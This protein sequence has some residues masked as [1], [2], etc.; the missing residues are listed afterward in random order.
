M[1]A[2][3]MPCL[4]NPHRA[5]MV[6]VCTYSLSGH[7]SLVALRGLTTCY[8]WGNLNS[9]RPTL[10]GFIAAIVPIYLSH[11]LVCQS[12]IWNLIK[13]KTALG[14][15]ISFNNI[16]WKWSEPKLHVRSGSCGPRNGWWEGRGNFRNFV[17]N[18]N[19]KLLVIHLLVTQLQVA[20]ANRI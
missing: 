13:E 2:I 8:M 20:V 17:T 9:K 7:C 5:I 3:P 18:L 1:S 15:S 10:H 19:R 16:H 12:I 14:N 11:T 4:L 6:L